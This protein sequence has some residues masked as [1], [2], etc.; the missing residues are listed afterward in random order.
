[1][2]NY[3]YAYNVPEGIKIGTT[4]N[5][6]KRRASHSTSGIS[7]K[8]FATVKINKKEIDSQLKTALIDL[9]K[10]ISIADSKSTEVFDLSEQETIA[11]FDYIKKY[12]NMSTDILR[13]ILTASGVWETHTKTLAEIKQSYITGKLVDFRFQRTPIEEHTKS[14]LSYITSQY[15]TLTY[16][17][18]AITVIKYGSTY[19]IVDGMHRCRAIKE[20]PDGHP[21]LL[22]TIQV[23]TNNRELATNERI[24][25]FRALNKT[26]PVHE[27]Y[28]D[29]NAITNIVNQTCGLLKQ[30]FGESIISDVE[31]ISI[32]QSHI[33]DFLTMQNINKLFNENK[34]R[35]ITN[36]EIAKIVLSIN[37]F[38]LEEIVRITNSEEDEIEPADLFDIDLDYEDVDERIWFDIH[39]FL[40]RV[41]DS[42]AKFNMSKYKKLFEAIRAELH[43]RN[44]GKKELKV[45]KTYNKDPFL[46]PLIDYSKTDLLNVYL[47][48]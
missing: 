12:Q 37:Q 10:Q 13:R 41:N 40:N 15:M 36:A 7:V 25:I 29:D 28:L 14:I 30:K 27:I 16:V 22:S 2:S 42:N 46:L 35:G 3:L 39:E 38:L 31:T 23:V 5:L 21:C 48:P 18:P 47:K 45:R 26:R 11:I 20:I 8:Y 44:S 19:E 34:I 24:V 4:K 43:L 9:D 1:M 6:E 17:L 33:E 32:R